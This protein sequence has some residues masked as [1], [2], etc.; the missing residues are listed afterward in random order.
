MNTRVF[1]T[2]LFLTINV[3]AFAQMNLGIRASANFV[4][5]DATEALDAI[6]PDL[7]TT[8]TWGVGAVSEFEFGDHF[9]L[10][11]ELM[12]T[13]KGFK[14]HETTDLE[15]FDIPLPVGV[16]AISKFG[17][18]EAP[19]LAKV[20]FGNDA[21]KAYLTAGP[22]FGYATNGRLITRAKAFFTIDL[23]DTK[24]DLDEIGYERFEVSGIVGAGIEFAVPSGKIF[25]DGRYQHGFTELYDIPLFSEKL[26]NR[27]FQLGA[28]YL[29]NF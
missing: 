10:Q 2:A 16:E 18:L 7:R 29:M 9:A 6:A 11:P 5:V 19:L 8:A 17:Y 24:I 14:I 21:V 1:A 27:G 4:H 3:A 22:A 20:K 13:V 23:F 12:Y 15:L 26:R 25:L 28:G